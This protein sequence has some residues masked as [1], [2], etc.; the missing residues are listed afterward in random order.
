[1]SR[2]VTDF[3]TGYLAAPTTVTTDDAAWLVASVQ[4]LTVRDTAWAQISSNSAR[5]HANLWRGVAALTPDV[6]A[7]LPVLA[8]VGMAGWI[9]GDGAL[10]NVALDRAAHVPGRETYTMPTC[11]RPSS[12]GCS[13]PTLWDAMVEQLR[14]ELDL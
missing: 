13:P 14:R 4:H 8:L 6:P 3:L 9:S 11:C 5:G 1:M 7:V 2:D 10:A 12:T